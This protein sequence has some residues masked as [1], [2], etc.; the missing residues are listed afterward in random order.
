VS[1]ARIFVAALLAFT[2][3]VLQL[4][5][6]DRVS[7]LWGQ[8]NLVV[9][10]V[11]AVALVSGPVLGMTLGFAS[12]LVADLLGDHLVGRL[13]LLF[14]VLGYAVGLIAEDPDDRRPVA[15]SVVVA[16]VAS[17]LVSLVNMGVGVLVGD[18]GTRLGS[19]L[20]AAA[21]AAA[22]DA[23]LTPF[24]FPLVRGLLARVAPG[25]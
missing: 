22:Y 14:T 24:V 11:V 6:V 4:T 9:L 19:V 7:L 3:L 17:A 2:A 13:A 8:P 5:A 12:G 23:L 10:V 18:P 15:V 1:P 20:K 25:R 21:A 16:A